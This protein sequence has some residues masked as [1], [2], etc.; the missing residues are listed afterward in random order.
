MSNKGNR[1]AAAE[2]GEPTYHGKPC[3]NCGATL[4]NTALGACIDCRKKSMRACVERFNAVRKAGLAG[5]S[6]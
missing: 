5:A 3:K 4:K 1:Y 6:S 2:A